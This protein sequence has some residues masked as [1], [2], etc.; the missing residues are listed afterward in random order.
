MERIAN[1]L[2][3]KGILAS[4]LEGPVIVQVFAEDGVRLEI[5]EYPM[6]CGHN[7]YRVKMEFFDTE[8]NDWMLLADIW[9][10]KLT[11]AANLLAQA[12]RY[13]TRLHQQAQHAGK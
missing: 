2:H 4:P 5:L 1:W 13:V 7:G 8:L 12:D 3:K 10:H 9:D 6:D 11:H